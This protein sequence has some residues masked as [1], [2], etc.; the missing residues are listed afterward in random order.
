MKAFKMSEESLELLSKTVKQFTYYDTFPFLV[1]R[2]ML[3]HK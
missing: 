3:P 1:D 2:A